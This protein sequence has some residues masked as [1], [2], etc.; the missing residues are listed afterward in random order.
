MINRCRWLLPRLTVLLSVCLSVWLLVFKSS[1]IIIKTFIFGIWSTF[2][3]NCKI[4]L[5]GM[6]KCNWWIIYVLMIS[7]IFAITRQ[8]S[9]KNLWLS[10]KNAS[11][12]EA[13]PKWVCGKWV[14]VANIFLLLLLLLL[15]LPSLFTL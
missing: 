1:E 5:T 12:W 11:S 13:S 2:E 7:C 4:M 10:K 9:Y 6:D 8:M 15:L 14:F 3:W